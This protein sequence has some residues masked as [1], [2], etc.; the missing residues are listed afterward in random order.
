MKYI[1]TQQPSSIKVLKKIVVLSEFFTADKW[2][3]VHGTISFPELRMR[4]VKTIFIYQ[5]YI[6]NWEELSYTLDLQISD[7]TLTKSKV[8]LLTFKSLP[9]VHFRLFHIN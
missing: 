8:Y 7:V 5:G 6:Q 4:M 9:H 2:K 3:W 1:S